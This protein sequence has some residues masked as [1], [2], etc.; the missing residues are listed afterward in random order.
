MKSLECKLCGKISVEHT[1]ECINKRGRDE[2]WP[3]NQAQ[4]SPCKC[5]HRCVTVTYS[6][7]KEPDLY[8]VERKKEILTEI[9]A[10]GKGAADLVERLL[11]DAYTRGLEDNF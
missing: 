11:V 7:R 3:D 1:Q 2:D 9:A 8:H 6:G 5:G 10:A 4:Q